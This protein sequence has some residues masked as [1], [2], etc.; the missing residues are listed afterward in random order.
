MSFQSALVASNCCDKI[1]R[2]KSVIL[3]NV[4]V[5]ATNAEAADGNVAI[6]FDYFQGK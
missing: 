2:E 1:L 5:V 6:S 3:T 4:F